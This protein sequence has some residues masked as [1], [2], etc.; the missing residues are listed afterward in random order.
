MK[1]L[2]LI[3]ASVLCMSLSLNS[4]AQKVYTLG[5]PPKV[6]EFI[7]HSGDFLMKDVYKINRSALALTV[8]IMTDTESNRKIG[9]VE[10]TSQEARGNVLTGSVS[11]RHEYYTS[12]LDADELSKVV[13]CLTYAKQNLLKTKPSA[14][15]RY[16]FYDTKLGGRIGVKWEY[17]GITSS[18]VAFFNADPNEGSEYE[19]TFSLGGH[20]IDTIIASFKEAETLINNLTAGE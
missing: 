8:I 5:Y 13:T 7:N 3:I 10:Y 1:R 4:F 17:S 20:S 15:P 6:Q 2:F 11:E 19:K 9:Y 16:F 18:W 12:M 14:N